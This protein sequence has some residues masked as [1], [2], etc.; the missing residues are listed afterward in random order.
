MKKVLFAILLALILPKSLSAQDLSKYGSL[1]RQ[2][3]VRENLRVR[4]A[5]LEIQL[6][7]KRRE[8]I[9]RTTPAP[10]VPDVT[11]ARRSRPVVVGYADGRACR[12]AA[13]G[14]RPIGCRR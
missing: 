4:E 2:Q 3:T 12:Y 9:R 10:V 5:I 8:M 11:L 7:E 13:I 1:A 14:G 6:E